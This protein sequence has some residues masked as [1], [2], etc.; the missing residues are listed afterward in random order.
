[1]SAASTQSDQSL[2][3]ISRRLAA[4][5]I[6]VGTYIT[7]VQKVSELVSFLWFGETSPEG[8]EQPVL[9]RHT[10]SNCGEP[11]RV[12]AVCVPF[13][14]VEDIREE[15]ETLDL[16]HCEVTQ[17]T[18]GYVDAVRQHR[19]KSKADKLAQKLSRRKKKRSKRRRK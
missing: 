4:E 15:A 10:P 2:H 19:Q 14:F 7:V 13:V 1:M 6:Q 17:L 5:D 9:Y 16:R 18:V 8:R 11:Y 12:L 3:T